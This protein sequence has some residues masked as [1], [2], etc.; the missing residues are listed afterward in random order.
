MMRKFSLSLEQAMDVFDV[1]ETQRLKYLKRA[2][3]QEISNQAPTTD[4]SDVHS[5]ILIMLAEQRNSKQNL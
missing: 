3:L 4:H 2:D 5:K 1:S